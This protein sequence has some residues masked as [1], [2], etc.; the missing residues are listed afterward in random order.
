M[1][2]SDDVAKV[3]GAEVGGWVDMVEDTCCIRAQARA[4]MRSAVVWATLSRT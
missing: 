2:A 4:C 1:G 3:A